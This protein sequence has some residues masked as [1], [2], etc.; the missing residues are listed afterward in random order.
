MIL[1]DAQIRQ[2]VE[3]KIIGIKTRVEQNRHKRKFPKIPKLG[4]KT[5][6]L[7]LYE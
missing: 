7:D 6:G 2:Q 4:L 3:K 5:I 1:T